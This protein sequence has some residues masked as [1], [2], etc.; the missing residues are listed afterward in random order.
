MSRKAPLPYHFC[1]II[2]CNEM[3]PPGAVF[4]AAHCATEYGDGFFP[5]AEALTYLPDASQVN[6]PSPVSPSAAGS[7][8]QT[9]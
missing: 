8:E 5:G 3:T 9:P 4:C 2:G 6:Q 1:V 7:L